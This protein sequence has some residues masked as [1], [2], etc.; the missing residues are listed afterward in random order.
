MRREASGGGLFHSVLWNRD[1]PKIQIRSIADLLEGRG[2][3]MPP[4]PSAYQPAQR[5]HRSLG[6]QGMMMEA[7]M[8]YAD[9][10]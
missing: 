6:E 9:G 5:V 8:P 1:Y 10:A 7:A 3:E 4:R 2:F